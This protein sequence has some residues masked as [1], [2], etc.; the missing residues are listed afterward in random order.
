VRQASRE[1]LAHSARQCLE[2]R[3]YLQSFFDNLADRASA[4]GEAW[5]YSER[6]S[7]VPSHV[8]QVVGAAV[9]ILLETEGTAAKPGGSAF[10]G[11]A[12]VAAPALLPLPASAP[13]LTPGPTPAGL[14]HASW[15]PPPAYAPP[16]APP[17]PLY[18]TPPALAAPALGSGGPSP[19]GGPAAPPYSVGTQQQAPG[20]A[21]GASRAVKRGLQ[22]AIDGAG[23]ASGSGGYGAGVGGGGHDSG[24]LSA[25]GGPFFCRAP[26]Q[27]LSGL[28]AGAQA[29][30]EGA[31]LA[32]RSRRP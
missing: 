6:A 22:A 28:T 4:T 9:R 10:G 26:S 29:A 13:V 14:G 12:S 27:A 1:V 5:T 25:T 2:I 17:P 24:G 3:Q 32:Q 7:F 30:L 21:V 23:A 16:A 20:P 8:M 19:F 18:A 15:G 11:A 31:L